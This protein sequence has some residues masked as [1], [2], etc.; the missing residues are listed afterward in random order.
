MASPSTVTRLLTSGMPVLR[1]LPS[2]ETL[3]TFMTTQPQSAGMPG[4]PAALRWGTSRPV[5]VSISVFSAP[6]G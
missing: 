1:Y 2:V 5:Q 3:V 6:W 4:L